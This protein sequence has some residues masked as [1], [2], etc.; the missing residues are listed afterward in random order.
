RRFVNCHTNE[1]SEYFWT[2]SGDRISIPAIPSNYEEADKFLVPAELRKVP[3]I[4][5]QSQGYW[6]Y[7]WSYAL[8]DRLAIITDDDNSII[9][10]WKSVTVVPTFPH[11]FSI[12]G[13][14]YTVVKH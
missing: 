10:Q 5:V 2:V 9:G 3:A 8:G 11:A 1:R 4:V 13:C 12:H 14:K 7:M 6:T